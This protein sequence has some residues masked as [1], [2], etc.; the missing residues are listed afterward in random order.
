MLFIINNIL[1]KRLLAF[2]MAFLLCFTLVV[3]NTHKVQAFAIVDDAVIA[4]VACLL[5]AVGVVD[6]ADGHADILNTA[7]DFVAY[8]ADETIDIV[9]FCSDCVST[10]GEFY[11]DIAKKGAVALS[12][13]ALTTFVSWFNSY[14]SA[15]NY[16]VNNGSAVGDNTVIS[17]ANIS[18]NALADV[19]ASYSPSLNINDF[20]SKVNSSEFLGKPLSLLT[21]THANYTKYMLYTLSVDGVYYYYSS[22]PSSYSSVYQYGYYNLYSSGNFSSGKIEASSST[23]SN[24]LH[25]DFTLLGEFCISDV[26][27]GDVALAPTNAVVSDTYVGDVIDNFGKDWTLDGTK[28]G[29]VVG[30]PVAPNG[31]LLDNDW[32][33]KMVPGFGFSDVIDTSWTD[34]IGGTDV[35]DPD[36]PDTDVDTPDYTGVLGGIKSL[37]QSIFD[38]L[39]DILSA[40]KGL[41]TGFFDKLK[42]LLLELFVPDVSLSDLIVEE[43]F[44]YIPSLNG[45]FFNINGVEIPDIKYNGVTYVNNSYIRKHISD[46]RL[47]LQIFVSFLYLMH[48]F[49]KYSSMFDSLNH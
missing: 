32:S 2:F 12:A 37:I 42:D 13:A 20:I 30:V 19:F 15:R 48:I 46:F 4:V 16:K 44:K 38:L 47:V 10:A 17:S 11:A 40:I 45:K 49:K 28:D 1:P 39:K 6:L 43:L 36:I 27:P 3:S 14:L 21:F 35:V 34:I 18:L 33:D 25:Q 7:A 31:S 26:L 5:V 9:S 22:L 8:C 24:F 29:V 41:F 23:Q